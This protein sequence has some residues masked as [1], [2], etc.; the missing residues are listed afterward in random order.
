[1]IRIRYGSGK[2]KLQETRK[3]KFIVFYL[4]FINSLEGLG[5]FFSSAALIRRLHRYTAILLLFKKGHSMVSLFPCSDLILLLRVVLHRK[6]ERK[7]NTWIASTR[8]WR[9][10]FADRS[11]CFY[12]W[13]SCEVTG[14]IRKRSV[15]FISDGNSFPVSAVKAKVMKLNDNKRDVKDFSVYTRQELKLWNE[16]ILSSIPQPVHEMLCWCFC[17]QTKSSK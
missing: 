4:Q 10:L 14:Q 2:R 6:H 9:F 5:K 12:K 1:M 16:E 13:D 17:W 3:I 8:E 11:H 15:T 7:P